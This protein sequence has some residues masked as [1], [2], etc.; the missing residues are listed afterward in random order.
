MKKRELKKK[1][2]VIGRIFRVLGIVVLTVVILAGL[3]FGF[4]AVT[5]FKPADVESV[6]TDGTQTKTLAAGD[7]LTVMTWNLGYGALGDNADFFMDGG[8]GVQTADEARL[9]ANL[10]GIM[11]E[12]W[13]ESP[14]LLLL[15]EVDRDSTRSLGVDEYDWLCQGLDGYT[16][17]FANNFKVAFLPYPIPPIG[18][19]D[20]GI[21]TFSAYAQED[22]QRV[23]LPI[24]FSWPVSMV[25]LKRCVMI[26][27]IPVAESGHELVVMNLHLEAYDDGEGKAAQ[28]EALAGLLEEEAAK[29]N[30]VVAGGDFNQIFS[31][32]N[33]SAYPAQEG[34]WQA[35]QIDV[36]QIAGDWQFMM[37]EDVPSC[38]SLDQPYAG[39][40]KA[41]FQYY[42]ID[43][44][45]VS[46][47]INV[48][49]LETKDLG[50]V[51]SDHNPVVMRLSLK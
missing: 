47:N 34:K 48:E 36:T 27:R 38:R 10:Q 6:Q 14:D 30:Y 41:G 1:R 33:G 37:D 19:V 44:F 29:G 8:N 50:F 2:S 49:Y 25:N 5:E 15:Q 16:S 28:T 39:A 17:A 7:H 9:D 24:P 45:I 31:S 12:I 23:Q 4:L 40:D 3:L 43:G 13:E 26:S 21:A 22:V 35:G 51:C 42:V 11:T 20:S 18:T 46:A 32:V